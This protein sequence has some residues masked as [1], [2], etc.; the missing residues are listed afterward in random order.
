MD[1]RSFDI[2]L[3]SKKAIITS[4]NISLIKRNDIVSVEILS[5]GIKF[6]YSD[7]IIYCDSNRNDKVAY[8]TIG[9]DFYTCN[10]LFCGRVEL[11]MGL[12]YCAHNINYYKVTLYERLDKIII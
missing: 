9:D 1:L 5:R 2:N 3:L 6:I 12:A 7:C 11:K 10:C 4:E 8:Y